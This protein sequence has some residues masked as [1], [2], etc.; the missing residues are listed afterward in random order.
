MAKNGHSFTFQ[1]PAST[2]N[3]GP[4]YGVLAVAV[5]LPLHVTVEPRNDGEVV[6]RRLDDP[7]AAAQDPRH[8]GVLRGLRQGLD[9]LEGSLGKGLGVTI[10]GTV[11]RGTGLGTVSAA[12]AAGLGIAARLGAGK[13]RE[14]V[15]RSRLLDLLV[16]LGGDPAHGAA[17]LAGGLVAAAVAS[18]PSVQPPRHELLAFPLHPD[19]R[20]VVALPDVAMATAD[21]KRVLP[22]TLPHAVTARTAGRVVAI[23]RALAEGDEALLRACLLD[24]THVPYRRRLIPGMEPALQAGV[25]AG[26]AASTVSG[27]GPGILALTTDAGRAPAIARAMSEAF[28]AAG[29]KATAL[30]LRAA[31]YGALPSDEAAGMT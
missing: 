2:A 23:L 1:V 30:V 22:P 16:Q 26:A 5:D 18:P 6:L 17:S 12:F 19:W 20:F 11:P 24:E 10:E 21:T 8:D 29:Q 31:Q 7:D 15:T 9:L 4:G 13:R 14:P 25:D 28:T 27:H 3:L